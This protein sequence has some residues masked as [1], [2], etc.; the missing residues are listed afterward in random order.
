[1]KKIGLIIVPVLFVVGGYFI[2]LS[3]ESASHESVPVITVMDILHASDL[4][5]GVKVAVKQGD[6][7]AVSGWLMKAREVAEVAGLSE[8][9]MA[10]LASQKARDYVI[11]NAK[12]RLFN[13][14]F[15]TRYLALEG[16]GDLKET[17]PEAV[18][19]FPKA[20]AL[21]A[22]R[23]TI[24]SQIALTLSNG[25]TPGSSDIAAAKLLWQ[26]RYQVEN[27]N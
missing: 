21:L 18:D 9:D 1:M 19:L 2:Y 25:Q 12:R 6:S 11:F 4:A 26:Q 7:D 16:I 24:I 14:A 20:E 8:N 3:D 27:K 22:K 15:E 13:E 17:Y 5:E 23:D 10:Y